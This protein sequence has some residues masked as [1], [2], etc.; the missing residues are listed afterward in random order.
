MVSSSPRLAVLPYVAILV[1]LYLFSNA[2]LATVLYH[3][4]MVIALRVGRS[5]SAPS[6]LG[7]GWHPFWAPLALVFGVVGGV[8]LAVLWPWFGFGDAFGRELERVGLSGFG[9]AVWFV[10]FATANAV[11]E[12]VFWRRDAPES[13]GG[14]ELADVLFAGYH[15]LVLVRFVAP[16]WAAASTVSLVLAA[17]F[18]RQ[19]GRKT[20]GLLPA[21]LSHAVANIA[22]SWAVYARL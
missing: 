21:V 22:I 19:L 14:I 3:G 15:F 5:P 4:G 17:W 9:L 8:A 2:W 1:G 6:R 7:R 10:Y 12:E 16:G 13:G 11:L 20:K 18:W